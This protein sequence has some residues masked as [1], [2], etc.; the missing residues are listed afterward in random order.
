MLNRIIGVS[1]LLCGLLLVS[2][3]VARPH[4]QP[5]RDNFDKV[6]RPT[7]E[8]VQY[9]RDVPKTQHKAVTKQG[10]ATKAAPANIDKRRQRGELWDGPAPVTPSRATVQTEKDRKYAGKSPGERRAEKVT[11]CSE[12]SPCSV[13]GT[14]TAASAKNNDPWAR[15]ENPRALP[16]TKPELW[17][18]GKAGA[19][20]LSRVR[21]IRMQVLE[22]AFLPEFGRDCRNG[23]DCWLP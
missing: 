2:S 22:K 6:G 10:T 1:G 4:P 13:S 5:G 20:Y 16:M 21:S 8:A 7:T 9:N 11:N 23:T 18:N 12:F 3:A 17:S 14:N 15:R 19:P